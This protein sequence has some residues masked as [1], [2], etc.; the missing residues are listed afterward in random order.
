VL[1]EIVLVRQRDRIA[2]AG[3]GV[4]QIS[5]LVGDR[6]ETAAGVHRGEVVPVRLGYPNRLTQCPQ[7]VAAIAV[8]M[9][10][11]TQHGAADRPPRRGWAAPLEVESVTPCGN[12]GADVAVHV[13]M[14]RP[15]AG[16]PRGERRETVPVAA[17]GRGAPRRLDP[18]IGLV[19]AAGVDAKPC[20]GQ[21]QVGIGVDRRSRQT[22]NPG[23]DGLLAPLLEE[24]VP[25][26][27]DQ[28]DG[29]GEVS[30]GGGMTDR[31]VD[32]TSLAVP[33]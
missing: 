33:A 21:A 19:E 22:V 7:G 27:G 20:L 11:Q 14:D 26:P 1:G 32:R 16:H 13:A 28:L 3:F 6:G 9:Q 8:P 10:R 12:R 18:T 5:P 31:L 2:R 4:G 24:L 15:E 29:L 23:G 25:V 30:C 17:V